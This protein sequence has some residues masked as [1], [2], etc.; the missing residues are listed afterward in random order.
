MTSGKWIFD[1]NGTGYHRGGWRCSLCN[2]I[3]NNLG[4]FDKINPLSFRGSRF[5][6]HCGDRKDGKPQQVQYEER[7]DDTMEKLDTIQT[8]GKLN[9]VYRYGEKGP[10]GAFHDYCIA[11][12]DRKEGK[13]PILVNI[14]FQKGPRKAPDS[15]QGVLDVDLIEIV[16]DRLKCFQM[17]EYAC[18]ENARAIGYLEA[19]LEAMNER[20]EDRARRGVLGTDKK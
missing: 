14:K 1:P 17:G 4:K 12:I 10:G 15:R 3:N 9:D 11:T 20:V 8:K 19:A 16:R 6:P 7:R 5:C 2:T 13:N 18:K